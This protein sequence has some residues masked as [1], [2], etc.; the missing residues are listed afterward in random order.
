[1][2]TLRYLR[3]PSFAVVQLATRHPSYSRETSDH[4]DPTD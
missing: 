1:M 2:K 3:R 4:D